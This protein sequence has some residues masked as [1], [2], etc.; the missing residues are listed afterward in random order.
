MDVELAE[1]RDF[2]AAHPPFDELPVAELDALPGALKVRYARRGSHLMRQGEPNDEVFIVR[3]GAVDISDNA[4]ELVERGDTGTCFGTTT[5]IEGGPSQFSVVA[6]EDLLVFVLPG[7]T[8]H[9]LAGRYPRFKAFFADQRKARMRGA[10][11]S[12]HVADT[13]SAILRTRVGD[14]AGR[15]PVTA[16]PGMTVREAAQLM[17]EANVSSLLIVENSALVGIITDRDLRRRVV[18]AGLPTERPV[19]EV[20]TPE[21]ETA[22]PD[23]LAFEVL[24]R[25][26]DGRIH[27]LP[28]WDPYPPPG[29][30]VGVV[31]ST[32]LVR[33]EHAN[34][35]Y[36]VRDVANQND[37]EGLARV[38]ARLPGNVAKL[39]SQDATASDIGRV[40]TAAGDAITRRLIALAEAE[41]GPPP[42]AYTWLALGSQ[43]RLEQV[44][45]SDQDHAI[46]YADVDDD[47]RA[48]DV[49]TYL[50]AL[51]ERVVAGLEACG[52]PRC[53][54][55]V[56]A[57]ADKCRMSWSQWKSSFAEWIREPDPDAVLATGIFFDARPVHGEASLAS[58]LLASAVTMAHDNRRFLALLARRAAAHAP[59]LGFFR[60]FVLGREGEQKDTL[61]LK[62]G[63]V[64]AVQETARVLALASGSTATGTL[65]R[66]EAA[67]H[68]GRIGAD[69]ASELADAY[70]FLA[71]VRVRHQVQRTQAGLPPDNYVRPDDLSSF[72]KRH[73]RDAFTTVRSA[74]TFLERSF[75]GAG[76]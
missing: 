39:V 64:G 33:L 48:H 13:G 50:R 43:A 69:R 67:T 35:I 2:L 73:L 66:L 51:A 14:M 70:E 16:A 25:M 52:Y 29:R 4:G 58:S 41:L 21:V 24:L 40:V 75:A 42:V 36:L 49:D 60:N 7:P 26:M 11:A 10:L 9:E 31:T 32:D 37:V 6:I 72:E 74:Q 56:M 61:D 62:W 12:V 19:S 47:T 17:S 15:D 57:T 44:L 46:V 34:P 38:A 53:P 23:D 28:I 30:A 45:G 18:A 68:A 59:P 22:G 65:D 27:H 20:M 63:G 54:G 5:V 1:I 55:D 3:S 71:Y 76:A 8:W